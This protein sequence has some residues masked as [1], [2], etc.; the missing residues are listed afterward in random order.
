MAR[1]QNAELERPSEDNITQEEVTSLRCNVVP[2]PDEYQ[3]Y[4]PNLSTWITFLRHPGW[5]MDDNA[6][7]ID[8]DPHFPNVAPLPHGCSHQLFEH[9]REGDTEKWRWKCKYLDPSRVRPLPRCT[10]T[11]ATFELFERHVLTVHLKE[12]HTAIQD[13]RLTPEWTVAMKH[14]GCVYYLAER[15]CCFK[16][17]GCA[18]VGKVGSRVEMEW[19]R[20]IKLHWKHITLVVTDAKTVR[21]TCTKR[22]RR[23]AEDE[24]D[25]EDGE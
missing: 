9:V 3:V 22:R 13:D 2:I 23:V 5:K 20:H 15:E 7:V 6:H 21:K 14:P 19:A 11:F 25:E 18:W 12:E 17:Y 10:R 8:Y 1:V 4:K 24:S 16:S